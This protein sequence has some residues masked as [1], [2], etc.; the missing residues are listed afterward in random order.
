MSDVDM[1]E[2]ER[3]AI[4][5]LRA[6]GFAV[7]IFYP[8]ELYGNN[9]AAIERLMVETVNNELSLWN[10]DNL[11]LVSRDETAAE[12]VVTVIFGKGE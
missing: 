12:N 4:N 6:K 2:A 9:P 8:E 7:A 5:T 1:T 11:T 3:T 10:A